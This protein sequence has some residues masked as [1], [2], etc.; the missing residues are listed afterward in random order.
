MGKSVHGDNDGSEGAVGE[1]A[2]VARIGMARKR[3][4]ASKTR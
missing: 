1:V 4:A 3:L 2:M